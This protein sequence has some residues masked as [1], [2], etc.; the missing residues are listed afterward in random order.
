MVLL[1]VS[2]NYLKERTR[3]NEAAI[4]EALPLVKAEVDSIE[5]DEITVE[6]T[7]DRPDLLCRQGIARAI[8]GFRC[9]EL[10]APKL[11]LHA[12]KNE[13][14]VDDNVLAVRPVIVC[15]LARGLTLRDADVAELMQVQEKLTLTHGRRRRKVA[16]GIHDAKAIKFPLRYAAYS[17]RELSFTPLGCDY[18]MNLDEILRDHPKGKEYAWTLQGFSRYPVITDDNGA[19]VSFPPIINGTMTTVTDVTNDLFLD[20]TG[21][22]FDACN[23]ALNILC[24]NYADDGARIESVTVHSKGAKLVCPDCRPE[25]MILDARDCNK[26]LGLELTKK[27]IV[28]CLAKQR[29]DAEDA[30]GRSVAAFIPRYRADFL[31]AADLIEEVALGYGYNAF[32]PLKPR[33]FTRGSVNALTELSDKARDCL[34]GAGFIE[35]AGFILTSEAKAARAEALER[36]IKIRNPVSKEYSALRA[37]LLPGVLEV[38]SENTHR[39]YPQ[40]LFEVGETIERDAA[41][42]ARSRTTLKACAVSAHAYASFSEAAT[43]L[44]ILAKAIGRD[45]FFE[46]A[47]NASGGSNASGSAARQF[48][49]GRAARVVSGNKEI[50]FVGEIHPRVLS[51][52]GLQVPATAFEIRL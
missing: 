41:S 18:Q 2:L 32:A 7:G 20:V 37:T 11:G 22:D 9:R 5:G 23:V 45:V 26:T 48:I 38:L 43:A 15:A 33:V 35:F 8:N 50:G 24:Q 12:T 3:W 13:V 47:S 31:H 14:V 49:E 34:A 4:L 51:A 21:T 17:G 28:N 42:D 36:V 27:E 19:V 16:I 46:R 44:T 52:Y 6:V 25:K 40:R 1:K 39:S 30:G 29:I 10:G